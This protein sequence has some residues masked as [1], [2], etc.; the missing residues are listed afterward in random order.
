MSCRGLYVFK[1]VGSDSNEAQRVRQAMLG[2]APAHRLL[3]FSTH[4]RELPGAIMDI[5]KSRVYPT[6]LT[7]NPANC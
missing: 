3:D 4:R 6:K 7:G 1:H 2:C 5:K